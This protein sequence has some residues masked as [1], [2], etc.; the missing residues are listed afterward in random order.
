[1]GGKVEQ[2]VQI[3]WGLVDH[4]KDFPFILKKEPPEGSE[5]S[6]LSSNLYFKIPARLKTGNRKAKAEIWGQVRSHC[7]NPGKRCGLDCSVDAKRL[8]LDTFL[9]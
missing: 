8:V 9:R 6:V 4:C 5:Q 2:G 3:V 1:M 7:N